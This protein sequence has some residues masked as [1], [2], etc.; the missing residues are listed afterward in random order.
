MESFKLNTHNLRYMED[1]K[2]VM[3]SLAIVFVISGAIAFGVNA[4][5]ANQQKPH[6]ERVTS[7]YNDLSNPEANL[8]EN[9]HPEG[10]LNNFLKNKSKEFEERRGNINNIEVVSVEVENG[11]FRNKYKHRNHLPSLSIM[12]EVVEE[13]E[14][15]ELEQWYVDKEKGIF[16]K[17]TKRKIYEIVQEEEGYKN[18]TLEVEMENQNTKVTS[19]FRL[20]LH[21][22]EWRVWSIN[23]TDREEISGP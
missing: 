12:D 9:T 13:I 4:T 1:Y 22:Y 2:V 7:Y 18:M 19:E 6:T 11:D 21:N 10:P 14:R 20:R 17:N 3:I 23:V 16:S 5:N 8:L 15:G